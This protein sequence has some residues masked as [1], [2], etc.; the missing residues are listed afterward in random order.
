MNATSHT[1]QIATQLNLRPEQVTATIELLDAGNTLPFIARYRKEATGGLDEEQLRQ[2]SA[3][4]AR[5]RKLDERR[6]TIVATIEKQGQLTP[7]LRQQLIEADTLAALEDL[8]RPY[9][10]K[11][12]TR[13][14]VAREKGL[15]GLADLILR[16]PCVERPV[17]QIAAPFL[18]PDVP[19]VKDALAGAR[20][21]VA[22]TISDHAEVRQATREKALQ[23]GLLCATKIA[24]AEDPRATYQL[25]YDF[26]LRVNRLRP[27]QILALN[28]GEAEKVLRVR[29]EV[30]EQDWQAAINS[31]F[32]PDR[33]SPLADQLVLAADDAAKRL[34]LPAIERD[35]RRILTEQAEAHAISI[36]AANLRALLNQPPLAG[37]TVLGIDPGFRTGCKVAVVDPTGKVLDTATIYPHAPQQQREAALNILASLVA[38]QQVTLIAI[39][40]G[41][42]SR[43]SEQLVAELIRAPIPNSPTPQY[44]IVSEA[45]ASV[46]SASPLARAELPGMDVS[47]RGAVS[48]ARRVQDPLAELVKID[49]QSIGVGM[50][51]HDV[52]QAQL[53]EAAA[54]AVESVVNSVGV[55]LNT[56][57][58]ALLTHVAGIGPKLSE[59]IV[60]YRDENGPFPSRMALKRVPGL[61]P[62]T[63]EQAAGFLRIRGDDNPLDGSAIHPESYGIA[64]AVLERAGLT[65]QAEQAEREAALAALQE[66]Q[67][68]DALAAELGAGVLTLADILEQLIR[69][70]RDPRASLPAP[71]LRS[72]VLTMDDLQPGIRLKG[73]VRNVVD[74]GAFVDVGV[75]QDGLLHRSKIPAGVRLRA[76]DVIDVEILQVEPERGRI[77][78]GWPGAGQN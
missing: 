64:Q 12:R 77:G 72:D 55:D 16:Q 6:Q 58:P 17:A 34:L 39:G 8:Y 50:Y 36:F 29:V 33:N 61:G 10:P 65:A 23:W 14:S 31:H 74:F 69:P 47:M 44:L 48:I 43:E 24:E 18:T 54:G 30:S 40:N 35:A 46:Y 78:L 5:L 28:R 4:L 41:T 45:G 21:I 71:I 42:A 68:L 19:T 66:R 32:R 7:E 57:S 67:S 62:K 26:E 27:H 75:K 73:T 13:A 56:A 15:Q 20:D 22:E 37:H 1:R 63:F 25:Y 76:G 2:L 11:R 38:R 3:L 53:A 70:G 9:K 60:D 49:P 52:D 59:R 51:Q